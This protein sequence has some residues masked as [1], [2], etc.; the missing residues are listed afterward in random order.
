MSGKRCKGK[1]AGYSASKFALMGLCQAMRNEGWD[2]GI[3]VTAICPGWVNTEM[4]R[5][6]S[7]LAPE[8]MTQPDD[9]ASLC[10][11]LLKLPASAVPF[12]LALNPTLES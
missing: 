6:I 4:A 11:Q 2:K 7:P 10:A 1:L 5:G 3:R 12:E 8:L 9:I